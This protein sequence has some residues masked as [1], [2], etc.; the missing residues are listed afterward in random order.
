MTEQVKGYEKYYKLRD[1][2]IK[3]KELAHY[4]RK[5]ADKYS[6]IELIKILRTIYGLSLVDAKEISVIYEGQYDSLSDYQAQ[7]IPV[8]EKIENSLESEDDKDNQL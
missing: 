7:F 3:P 1:R 2:G 4:Y 5:N 8:L 6:P